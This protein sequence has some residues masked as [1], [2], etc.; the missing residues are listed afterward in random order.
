MKPQTEV[1]N[2]ELSDESELDDD[3]EHWISKSQLK[4]DSKD[5]QKLGKKLVSYTPAQ[6]AK[7][8]LDE[9]MQDAIHLAHKIANKRSASKRHF[10][11]IGKLLRAI[12]VEPIFNAVSII[13]N[14]DQ[15]NKLKFKKLEHWRD[16]IID[17]GDV[18]INDCCNT[19]SQIDRQNLRQLG[20]NY[21]QAEN[22]D[23]K[24]RISRQ[25]FKLL[26]ESIIT[27]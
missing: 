19:H 23:K 24:T 26:R 21:R 10:Q 12:D 20:R 27:E 1:L 8:P 7:V 11:F 13:E 2:E 15:H 17:E 3:Q 25:I 6:L 18:A 22:D 5:L 14:D 4:R 16:R 9:K